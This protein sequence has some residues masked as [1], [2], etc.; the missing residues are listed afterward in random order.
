[1]P[2]E[3]ET[4]R[5]TVSR[6][7][8]RRWLPVVL[9]G[10][11]IAV[12]LGA[13]DVWIIT[14]TNDMLIREAD[15]QLRT[16]ALLGA[17]Q[18]RGEDLEAITDR[19]DMSKPEF[20]RI[21]ST[22]SRIRSTSPGFTWV[23]TMRYVGPGDL[24][25][26]LV[27]A[28]PFSLDR[29]G[30][31]VLDSDEVA[32]LPGDPYHARQF[33]E[34][35]LLGLEHSS[36]R[37][38][39]EP[40]P[41]WGVLVTGYAPVYDAEG[42]VKG[43]L[44]IDMVYADLLKKSDSVMFAVIGV[45]VLLGFLLLYTFYLYRRR[46]VAFSQTVLLQKELM[47][48]TDMFAKFVP[49]NVRRELERNPDAS[50]L[51]RKE[52]DVSVMFLD[53]GGYTRMSEIVEGESLGRILERY[54]S[55]FLEVIH[56][57]RGQVNETAGDGLMVIFQENAPVGHALDAVEAAL[58]I[59]EGG[60]NIN[61]ELEE[62]EQPVSVN[63]GINSGKAFVGLNRFVGLTGERYT[64]TATGPTTNIAARV[65]G[66][67]K[68]GDI[69]LSESTAERVREHLEL[70]RVGRRTLKNVSRPIMIFRPL[71]AGRAGRVDPL[72]AHQT[73]SDSD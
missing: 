69:L 60:A 16:A 7:S 10:V 41:P 1:M 18:V 49:E 58:E 21:Q 73:E 35:M 4:A 63:I 36:A 70:E 29:D 44:A 2:N 64:Y 40:D 3:A 50:S 72:V 52:C 31:G 37:M 38:I 19:S 14:L 17:S 71:G 8:T 47:E 23:Y 6:H 45:S 32:T 13:L 20:H 51:Q 56:H 46:T 33:H 66:L 26:Y 43:V 9:A 22:L 39:P 25:E 42:E 61:A 68:E 5:S 53:L 12:V 57:H 11:V 67:A 65:A 15:Q 62:G 30:N 59:L 27:D 34:V 28:E 48:V 24:W 54:F 55:R